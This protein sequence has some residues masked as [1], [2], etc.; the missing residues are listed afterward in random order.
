[1]EHAGIITLVPTFV[2]L[3]TAII[4][5]RPVASLI[6]GVLIGILLNTPK[7]IL[8]SFSEITLEVM[9]DPQIGWVIMV[10]GLM[11]SLFYLLMAAGGVEAFTLAMAKRANTRKKSLLITWFM[12]LTMFLDDYL[13]AIVIGN[14]MKKVT[15]K[16]KV[17]RSMLAYIVDS[18]AAPICV[19]VPI[20]TWA[21]YFSVILES[22]ENISLGEGMTY[23]ISA[24]PFMFYPIIALLLV[25][26]VASERFPLIGPMKQEELKASQGN[27]ISQSTEDH[28]S[29]DI[30]TQSNIWVFVLPLLALILFSWFNNIDLLR[31]IIATLMLVIPIMIGLKIIDMDSAFNA[32]LDGFK[33]MI[34]PLMIVVAAFMFK[35]INDQLGMPQYVIE[36]MKP[37]LSPTL[38]PVIVFIT[39]AFVSFATASNWGIYLI[40]IPI[41]LPL[42]IALDV[43]IPLIIG[44]VLSAST[45]GSH[46]CFYTDATVLAAQSSGVDTMKHALTQIPYALIAA[47]TASIAYIAYAYIVI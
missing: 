13:S 17:S 27:S 1:M 22:T 5:H 29:S 24:I 38:F 2:V 26:L 35:V 44:A 9:Q 37:I 4:T 10:C 32:I 39:M 28:D 19:L 16:F 34:P 31:G 43:P 41:V 47:L 7:N 3:A 6:V 8:G 12:G 20:S 42:G 45:F 25:P 21:V 18:T 14:S 46:A 15:D 33:V 11:G 40:V 36:T 30:R 23:Y